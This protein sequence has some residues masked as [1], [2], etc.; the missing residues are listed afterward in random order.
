MGND[1]DVCSK[2]ES[3]DAIFWER[4]GPKDETTLE[5]FRRNYNHF[6]DSLSSPER[7]VYS[8]SDLEML[9][10]SDNSSISPAMKI[11]EL[12]EF[13]IFSQGITLHSSIWKHI[14]SKNNTCILYLHTNRN[15]LIDS[16][17]ILP[18]ANEMESSVAA[19]DLPGC[20]KS[21]GMLSASVDVDIAT[22]IDWIKCILGVDV[23]IIIWSRGMSTAAAIQFASKMG[24]S[25]EKYPVYAILLD[26]PFVSFEM[27]IDDAVKKMK[28]NGYSLPNGIYSISS[29]MVLSALSTRLGGI[30]PLLIKPINFASQCNIPCYIMSASQDD[31]ISSVHGELIAME[32]NGV[33]QY[34]A[35]EGSHY[36]KRSPN[37]VL[38]A[39]DFLQSALGNS[40]SNR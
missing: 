14:N 30:N 8:S 17:E 38:S 20:G 21:D 22:M 24:T 3:I 6:I 10:F 23:K 39:L 33:I 18:L 4:H 5:F 7:K 34:K 37:L 26:S 32:W 16:N 40:D 9:C 1:I 2:D 11:Y 12:T 28:L 35:F 25:F 19:F 36:G 31:Y 13:N 15:C 29:N 27:M